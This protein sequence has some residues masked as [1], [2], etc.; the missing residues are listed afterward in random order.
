MDPEFLAMQN[1]FL[2][3]T[4]PWRESVIFKA[5]IETILK[6]NP[7]YKIVVYNRKIFYRF[8][9][10][11]GRFVLGTRLVFFIIPGFYLLINYCF[12]YIFLHGFV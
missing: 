3:E 2:S 8:I 1:H 9:Q 6:L 12:D 5:I 11:Y 7:V 10:I 4:L